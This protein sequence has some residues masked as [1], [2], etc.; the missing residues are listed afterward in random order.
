MARGVELKLREREVRENFTIRLKP[1]VVARI[2]RIKD[3]MRKEGK[4]ISRSEIIEQFLIA[5]L[6]QFVEK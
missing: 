3:A 1:D 4:V 5:G 2:Q 6:D